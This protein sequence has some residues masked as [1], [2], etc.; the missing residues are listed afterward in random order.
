M[1]LLQKDLCYPPRRGQGTTLLALLG[2]VLVACP[3]PQTQSGVRSPA[4][5]LTVRS[6]ESLAVIGVQQ[7]ET[8]SRSGEADSVKDRRVGFGLNSLLAESLFDTSRFRLVEEKD[9]HQ[10]ELLAD[11]VKTYW[12]EARAP[13]TAQELQRVAQ[14]L[15]VALLAYGRV[16]YSGFSGH[17]W[18]VGPLSRAEQKLRLQVTA[19]LYDAST[20]AALC[21]QGQGEARQE[22]VGVVYEFSGDR[23][24]FEQNAVG[25]ATKQAVAL[26]VG[27]LVA[28]LTFLP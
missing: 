23:L 22:G 24:D 3:A 4:A 6:G 9:V 17:R 19:C 12:I 18:M 1:A 25:R 13:Y 16:A 2:L 14:Q 5:G 8:P 20:R 11:L 10:R 21:R 26:A 27:E 15:G 28:S 7:G